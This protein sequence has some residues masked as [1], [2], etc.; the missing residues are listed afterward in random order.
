MT[1]ERLG[2]YSSAVEDAVTH[3]YDS[4]Y[5]PLVRVIGER[6]IL[7]DFPGRTETDLYV[8]IVKH[9]AALERELG[10][11]IDPRSAAVDLATQFS[12]KPQHAVGR[13]S[14]RIIEA[15]LPDALGPG[16]AA[17]VWRKERL[18]DHKG[19]RLFSDIL[20]AI[21]GDES[22]WHALERA[23]EV[24]RR[25]EARLHGLFVMPSEAH[26]SSEELQA[27]QTEFERRCGAAHIPGK[28]AAKAGRPTR[29]VPEQSR[30]MDLVVLGQAHRYAPT[31][32][33]R[34][35]SGLRTII[36]RCPTPVLVVSESAVPF[37][38]V[39]LAYDG[40]P[41]AEQALFV[42]TY[43]A[44]QWDL[45]LVVVTV[46]ES[47]RT[48]PDTLRHAQ[49]YLQTHAVQAVCV[50]ENGPAAKVILIAAEEHGADLIVI[51]GY[52]FSPIKEM[53]LG[54]TL[55]EVLRSSGR[56]ILICQ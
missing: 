2:D 25:E 49:T 31:P 42:A 6:G 40:S 27:L 18:A 32:I 34:L 35:A 41:K 47:D 20:V 14:R 4:F 15:V 12:S 9:W 16:Q 43:V 10:W 54:S 3:W 53:A 8:W 37:S 13:A 39:L 56:P 38:R 5:L 1:W 46:M 28:L 11:E 36:R 52:G 51:G 44:G 45:P 55:G 33:A 23:Q 50:R 17:G 7:R 19:E 48:T 26:R 30:F 29:L 22:G 24:A 21:D